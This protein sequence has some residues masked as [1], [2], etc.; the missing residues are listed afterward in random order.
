MA[1]AAP[2]TNVSC[3]AVPVCI[4]ALIKEQAHN[5]ARKA[6]EELNHVHFSQAAEEHQLASTYFS[7]AGKGTSDAEV[8]CMI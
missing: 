7:R 6:A 5:H 1:E 2:L 3:L 4:L 8:T